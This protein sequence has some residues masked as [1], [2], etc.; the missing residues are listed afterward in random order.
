MYTVRLY[1]KNDFDSWNAFI[2]QA[3]NATFLFH[4][5]FMEYHEDRFVDYSLIIEDGSKCVAVLPANFSNNQVF[6]HQGLSYGGLVYDKKTKLATVLTI[7]KYILEFLK[8]NEISKF[9]VKLTPSFY[10]D[11]PSDELNYALFLTEAKLIRRDTHAIIELQKGISITKGRM[12]GVAKAIKQKLIIKEETEFHAFW[13]QILIPNLA[14]MHQAKPVHTLEEIQYLH[15]KFPDNI[16]QFNVYHY[17]KLVAG[18]TIFETK[19]VAHAQYISGNNDKGKLGSVDFLYHHLLTNIFSHKEI[20][21]FGI[22]NSNEG[23]TLNGGLSFWKESFGAH[24]ISQ[25][26]Y[27]VNTANYGLLENVVL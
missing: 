14:E 8:Q 20:F 16:R 22:S 6:S 2:D 24:I 11:Y 3:K 21:D 15:Q 5:N 9:Q 13:N 19:N 17:D 26:F 1:Q 12:E 18:T 10:T 27:E 7:F 25:D 4:R 23:K